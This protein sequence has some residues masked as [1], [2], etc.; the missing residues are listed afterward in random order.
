MAATLY[1]TFGGSL[2]PLGTVVLTWSASLGEWTASGVAA[3][4]GSVGVRF[5]C[6][7][8]SGHFAMTGTG[9]VEFSCSAAAVTCDPLLW[10]CA[11]T[12]LGGPCAGAYTVEVVD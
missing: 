1:A 2:S 3:C 8:A 5:R 4:G 12:A 6:V 7:I 10:Q 11:G 9:P